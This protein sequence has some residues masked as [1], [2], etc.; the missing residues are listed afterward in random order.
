MMSHR[1]QQ[2]PPNPR[3]ADVP[4]KRDSTVDMTRVFVPVDMECLK[5]LSLYKEN[6]LQK[7]QKDENV[8]ISDRVNGYDVIGHTIDVTWAANKMGRLVDEV[9]CS[10]F[11]FV[12]GVDVRKF[13]ETAVTIGKR[14]RCLIGYKSN[15]NPASRQRSQ[16]SLPFT[17]GHRGVKVTVV[18][19]RIEKQEADVIVNT[20]NRQLN[21][22]SGSGE[23]YSLL[24]MV[25][26]DIQKVLNHIYPDGI[27]YGHL[28]V[29]SSG[30]LGT[31]RRIY[32][33]CLPYY[34][35]YTETFSLSKCYQCLVSLVFR[36]LIQASKDGFETIALPAFGTG[37]LRYP[38]KNVIQLMYHAIDLFAKHNTQT[39]LKK[40]LIVAAFESRLEVKQLFLAYRIT[41]KLKTRWL[42]APREDIRRFFY[43]LFTPRTERI[44]IL[45]EFLGRE[46]RRPGQTSCELRVMIGHTL[47]QIINGSIN[48]V[49]N[50]TQTALLLWR[51]KD[52]GTF[53]SKMAGR[54]TDITTT[55]HKRCISV[56]YSD[57]SEAAMVTALGTG[58]RLAAEKEWYHVTVPLAA[59]DIVS[60]DQTTAAIVSTLERLS[61]V[62]VVTIAVP[63]ANYYIDLVTRIANH[64]IVQ[65]P[66]DVTNSLAGSQTNLSRQ[67]SGSLE[68][69]HTTAGDAV[70]VVTSESEETNRNAASDVERELHVQLQPFLHFHTSLTRE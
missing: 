59:T 27:E 67:R 9:K 35:G 65:K 21:L 19:N 49:C 29:T 64:G 28:A 22:S 54:V 42:E 15:V 18:F 25:G 10:T 45:P 33:G 31:C 63:N 58:L 8:T 12:T 16:S 23:S 53:R 56:N 52:T 1:T 39:S 6:E 50:A 3:V 34:R 41:H 44:G 24:Q 70:M 46:V 2:P 13:A 11:S 36:C 32:H 30:N 14:Y 7:I 69:M 40:I 62:Y 66:P 55:T 47:V 68:A 17:Q 20:T 51:V 5:Y 43:R 57:V 4:R 37:A 48:E 26:S 38:T 60:P 61:C